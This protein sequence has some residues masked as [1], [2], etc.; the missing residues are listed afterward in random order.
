MKKSFK[1]RI[2]YVPDVPLD[3]IHE[4]QVESLSCLLGMFPLGNQNDASC[5][6]WCNSKALI[7]GTFLILVEIVEV[8]QKGHLC[9]MWGYFYCS[10]TSNYFN[11]LSF[12]GGSWVLSIGVAALIGGIY[13][14]KIVPTCRCKSAIQATSFI[15]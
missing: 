14:C 10:P 8:L 1:R 11:V 12:K 9:K 5:K 7:W 4:L 3:K 15:F 6:H 2:F 13:T